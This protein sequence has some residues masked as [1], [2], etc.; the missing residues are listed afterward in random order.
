MALISSDFSRTCK[1]QYI[2]NLTDELTITNKNFL[3][4]F[5]AYFQQI[6]NTDELVNKLTHLFELF[7]VKKTKK[8]LDYLESMDDDENEDDE[9]G[10]YTDIFLQ[11]N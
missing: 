11:G 9:M 2:N 8:R 4:D 7:D 1:V 6:E 10:Y 3:A 5:C